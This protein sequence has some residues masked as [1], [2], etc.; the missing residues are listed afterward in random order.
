MKIF[1]SKIWSSSVEFFVFDST[2]PFLNRYLRLQTIDHAM[3]NADLRC[4]LEKVY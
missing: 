1:T 2:D 4:G 3:N